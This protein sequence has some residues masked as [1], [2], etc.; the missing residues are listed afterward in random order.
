MADEEEMADLEI[1]SSGPNPWV[2]MIVGALLNVALVVGATWFLLEGMKSD[3]NGLVLEGKASAEAAAAAAAETEGLRI[4]IFHSLEKFTVNIQDKNKE[5]AMVVE[6]KVL[7]YSQADIDAVIKFDAVIRD[8]LSELFS[9]QNYR[10]MKSR[11]GK[12]KLKDKT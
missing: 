3:L 12:R 9:S 11:D 8:S 5:R 10:D 7:G 1:E 4:P 2:I 6:V